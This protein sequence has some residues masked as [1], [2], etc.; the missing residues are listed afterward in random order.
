MGVVA[1]AVKFVVETAVNIV[2]STPVIGHCLALGYVK[3]KVKFDAL[4][5]LCAKTMSENL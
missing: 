4:S 1:S 5:S 3:L 2:E